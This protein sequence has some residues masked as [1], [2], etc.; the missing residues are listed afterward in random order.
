MLNFK[1]FFSLESRF[2]TKKWN[3]T[4]IHQENSRENGCLK[5]TS[6]TMEH[7]SLQILQEM[8]A[9]TSLVMNCLCADCTYMWRCTIWSQ[10]WKTFYFSR[11]KICGFY[12]MDIILMLT[13]V[14]N[15]LKW[16]TYLSRIHT[17]MSHTCSWI[18]LFLSLYFPAQN[19]TEYMT[20]H[21]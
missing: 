20:H 14:Q 1:T 15:L 17:M 6:N 8:S 7:F 5:E 21:L 4:I 18:L 10:G 12:A 3:I 19:P 13:F 2:M 11:A 16:W 9:Y